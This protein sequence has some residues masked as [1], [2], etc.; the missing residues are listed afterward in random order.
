LIKISR[1]S[2]NV[3]SFLLAARV[4]TLVAGWI[5]FEF[6]SF[7]PS[8][9]QT[10]FDF[11]GLSLVF[12]VPRPFS[13]SS[14][15]VRQ[16][17]VRGPSR[18]VRSDPSLY[19]PV[20]T[21][22]TRSRSCPRRPFCSGFTFLCLERN[23]LLGSEFRRAAGDFDLRGKLE[24]HYMQQ[25]RLRSQNADTCFRF[26]P[27]CDVESPCAVLRDLCPTIVYRV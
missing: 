10:C 1:F 2:A 13:L 11:V 15:Q 8:P 25:A 14:P 18:L 5:A 4:L 6:F 27:M 24:T 26:R 12:P 7:R 20:K 3:A 21:F 22:D 16:V 19:D 17:H 23:G 9:P